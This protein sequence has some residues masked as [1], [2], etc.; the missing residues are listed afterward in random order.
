MH[1]FFDQ[2]DS[3]NILYW[4]FPHYVK[5]PPVGEGG[6]WTV[7]LAQGNIEIQTFASSTMNS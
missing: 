3:Y 6:L 5:Q 4:S 2:L 7:H 1:D